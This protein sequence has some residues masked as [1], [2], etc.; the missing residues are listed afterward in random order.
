MQLTEKIQELSQLLESEYAKSLDG[1][2]RPKFE[3]GNDETREY[4]I[5]FPI[6]EW[7]MNVFG[8]MH[9][10][11]CATS[12][13]IAMGIVCSAIADDKRVLT[14]DMFINYISPLEGGD[15]FEVTVKILRAGRKFIRLEA[16][17]Y[18]QKSGA[19]IATAIA[20]Y[21]LLDKK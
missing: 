9:G 10:G 21:V 16:E 1:M 20:S 19:L 11:I 7:Q 15:R 17:G 18:S 12:F 2:M 13:D 8:I 6:A 14:V 5:S 4:T 3:E